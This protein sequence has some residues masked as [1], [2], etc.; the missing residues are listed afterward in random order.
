MF[1]S[2]FLL[3]I[4]RLEKC[5][6]HILILSKE[7]SFS[8]AKTN[9]KLAGITMLNMKGFYLFFF[10]L[11]RISFLDHFSLGKYNFSLDSFFFSTPRIF[12]KQP[13]FVESPSTYNSLIWDSL[14]SDTFTT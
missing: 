2:M 4:L 3:L 12:I 8:V 14:K 6:S 5:V 11:I 10:F 1:L 13:G 7:K 9:E